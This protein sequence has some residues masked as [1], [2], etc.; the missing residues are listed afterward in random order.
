MTSI[1]FICLGNI[2]RSSLAEGIAKERAGRL[3]LDLLIESAGLSTYHNGE[4]PCKVSQEIAKQH[5]TD[6]STQV[7]QHIS[8]FDLNDF[9][10]VVAM[11]Q[12]NL[13]ELERLGVENLVK[14]G[15]FGYNGEDV[16]DLY[17]YPEK[18][19]Y[20]YEMINGA[21]QQILASAKV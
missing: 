20:V 11:D 9:D 6:I 15:D 12:S 19:S 16:S 4:A 17:Y 13:I 5:G 1:I 2:C 18:A 7:S 8:H 10:M 14:L 3:G 21:T